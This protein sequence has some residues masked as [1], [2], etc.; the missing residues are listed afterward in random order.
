MKA[1]VE[2]SPRRDRPPGQRNDRRRES[3]GRSHPKR[4]SSRERRLR[5]LDVLRAFFLSPE[6]HELQD[7][8]IPSAT[9]VSEL[10]DRKRELAF[11]LELLRAILDETRRELNALRQRTKR[12][13]PRA[14]KT[15]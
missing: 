15:R 7:A 4:L 9:T 11:R 8:P 6:A 1:R 3:V 12:S 13:P 2:P 14:S 5:H 10:T